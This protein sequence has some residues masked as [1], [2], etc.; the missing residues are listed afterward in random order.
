[1]TQLAGAACRPGFKAVA[2]GLTLDVD[3][4]NSIR[5]FNS[6][7]VIGLLPGGDRKHEYVLV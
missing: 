2:M 6:A 3:V 5:R 1:M 7:N 4:K